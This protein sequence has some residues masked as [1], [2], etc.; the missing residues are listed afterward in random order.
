MPEITETDLRKWAAIIPDPIRRADVIQAFC[1][2]VEQT[3]EALDRAR[4]DW[5][6]LAADDLTICLET[7]EADVRGRIDRIRTANGR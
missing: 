6:Y 4:A 2:G 3:L 7:W 5:R 1:D